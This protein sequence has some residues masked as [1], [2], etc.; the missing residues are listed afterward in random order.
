MSITL[1]SRDIDHVSPGERT[2]WK[3]WAANA[4]NLIG[5]RSHAML[6]RLTLLRDLRQMQRI[7]AL[8]WFSFMLL[9]PPR[10]I[11]LEP[12]D[13]RI[14]HWAVLSPVAV[15]ELAVLGQV[16]PSISSAKISGAGLGGRL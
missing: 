4:L 1:P 8:L 15:P 13:V 2:L 9:F 16:V 10:F 6:M 5:V 11:P 14:R 3:R 7:R 12:A